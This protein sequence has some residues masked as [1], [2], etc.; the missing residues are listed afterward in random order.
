[1]KNLRLNFFK[2]RLKH[3]SDYHFT[4]IISILIGFLS[5]LVA[6]VIKSAVELVRSIILLDAIKHYYQYFYFIFPLIGIALVVVFGKYIIRK[7]INDGIPNVLYSLSKKRGVI[8]KHNMFSS[9]ITSSITVGF[10]GSVGLE[11]PTVATGAAFGSNVAHW[12]KLKYKEKTLLIACGCAATMAALFKAPMAGIVFAIE[13]IMLDLTMTSIIPLLASS[14]TAVVTGYYFFGLDVIYPFEVEGNGIIFSHLPFYVLLGIAS[15]LVALHFTRFSIFSE[16][17]FSNF[18]TWYVK[19]LI[20]G[21]I[22]GGLIY[23]FPSLYGEG[24]EAINSALHGNFKYLT[25]NTI[26]ESFADNIFLIF[27]LFVLVIALKVVATSVTFGSGGIGGIFAPTLFT[28]A[29]TGLFFAVFINYTGIATISLSNFAMLGMGGL[30][31]GVLQAPLT[32]V[33]L[34]TDL[35]AGYKLLVPL[36]IV[37]GFSYITIRLFE[38]NSIYTHQLA[39]RGDLLTHN[40][41]KNILSLMNIKSL[42]ET[43]FDKISPNAKLRDLVDLISVTHR[44]IFAVVDSNNFFIGIVTLDNVR[45]VMFKPELYDEIT[46]IELMFIPEVKVSINDTMEEVAQKIQ[47]SDKF[48]I[49]VLDEGKYVGFVS[50]ANVFSSYRKLLKHFSDY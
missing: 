48:N 13:V 18:K 41:D 50:R 9:I 19:L 39:K 42:I 1:M 21:L 26:F 46:V 30:I 40:K 29:N 37:A 43:D 4:I 8:K 25:D 17:I 32:A 6:Y 22:L 10:G 27:G 44:N 16:K 45:K 34:I 23:L 11:G 47:N 36:A 7:K 2:W 24:Y 5:G 12:F 35:T 14:V 28:G 49:V 38:K 33:F 20:G 31:T 15:G 3:I